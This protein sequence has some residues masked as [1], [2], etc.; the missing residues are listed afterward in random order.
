MAANLGRAGGVRQ[1]QPLYSGWLASTGASNV[2][3]AAVCRSQTFRS[4]KHDSAKI[5]SLARRAAQLALAPPAK[6]AAASKIDPRQRFA[7]CQCL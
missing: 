3:L 1:L 2:Q 4:A 6:G 7:E 5:L